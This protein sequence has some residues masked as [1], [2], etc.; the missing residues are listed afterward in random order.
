MEP[1]ILGRGG[2]VDSYIGDAIMALFAVPPAEAVAA[3]VEMHRRLRPINAARAAAGQRTIRIGVGLNTGELTLGTIGGPQRIKCGVIGDCV[4]L[5]ARIESLTKRYGAGLIVGERTHALL[6]PEAFLTRELDRVR[7]V[8]RLAPVTLYEVLDADD[9]VLRD[10][11]RDAL[12]EWATAVQSWRAG[13]VA[14]A[15]VHFR[16]CRDAAPDDAAAAL[17]LARCERALR[18]G[19]TA[20]WSDVEDLLEK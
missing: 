1:A 12:S 15:A 7:V 8:G 19:P 4:N 13:D 16:R 3:G 20:P 18:E 14:E 9:D 6:P 5:A 17:R 2:F 10:A 11:K